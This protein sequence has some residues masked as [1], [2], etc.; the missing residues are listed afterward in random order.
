MQFS[1]A[2][3]FEALLSFTS[4]DKG[5]PG[6]ISY[7]SPNAYTENEFWLISPGLVYT[8][9][10]WVTHLFYSRSQSDLEGQGPYSVTDD[11]IESDELSVLFDCTVSD[12]ILLS[13]GLL[14]RNEELERK[15]TAYAN[16]S[17]QLGSYLQVLWQAGGHLELR[18]GLRGD[19]YSDY[20]NALTANLEFIYDGFFPDLTIFGKVAS[21]YAPPSANDLAYDAITSSSVDPEQGLSYELGLRQELD[22]SFSWTAAFFYNDME[23]LIEFNYLGFYDGAYQ[24]DVYNVSDARMQGVELGMDWEPG[25]QITCSLGY[26]Y[27]ETE[28]ADGDR[29][30]RRPRHS[31][32]TTV[33]FELADSIR[34]GASGFGYFDSKETGTKGDDYFLAEI[35][36]DW[37]ISHNWSVY[38]R[39]EN[40][41]DLEYEP[42][43]DYP[44][45]GRAGYLGTSYRF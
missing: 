12:A 10:A 23:D 7:P 22:E 44:A 18:G 31:L 6:T 4:V 20:D 41:F 5:L 15:P 33:V 45:L 21:S 35:S 13:Y 27:L 3:S 8:G 34:L 9:D 38:A 40:L 16:S 1:E 17:S 2:L 24:Y 11:E 26:T 25:N 42:V 43:P 37:A 29:L 14:Y 19:Q 36:A 39:V 30:L 32:Q 28:D